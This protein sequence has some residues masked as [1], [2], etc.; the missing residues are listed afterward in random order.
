MCE[1]TGAGEGSGRRLNDFQRHAYTTR[2]SRHYVRPNVA[3]RMAEWDEVWRTLPRR[4]IDSATPKTRV[5]V[6]LKQAA[7]DGTETWLPVFA[8]RSPWQDDG[9]KSWERVFIEFQVESVDGLLIW[10]VTFIGLTRWFLTI[11]IRELDETEIWW[12]AEY[13]RLF[14]SFFN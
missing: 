8:I 7:P 4:R 1:G 11:V 3:V 10:R 5:V 2:N 14:F 9:E 6:R 13:K 12:S